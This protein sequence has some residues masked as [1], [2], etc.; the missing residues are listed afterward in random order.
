MPLRSQDATGRRREAVIEELD[1]NADQILSS[2]D[3]SQPDG[4]NV[5]QQQR[6]KLGARYLCLIGLL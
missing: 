6:V 2:W 4:D 1:P 3:A 5:Q